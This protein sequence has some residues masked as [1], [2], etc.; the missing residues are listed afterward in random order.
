LGQRIDPENRLLWKRTIE[1]LDAEEIRD[2]MLAVSGELDPVI[3]GPSVPTSRPRRTVFTRV[4]RNVR[5]QFL[6]AFDA[7][8]GN[9]T[10]PRRNSTTAATQALLMING[11][12]TLARAKAVAA[13]L[14]PSSTD[15]SDRIV[16]AYRLALGRRPEPGEIADGLTFVKQQATRLT[17]SAQRS[18]LQASR[19]ALVDFCHVLLN[20]NEFLYVD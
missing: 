1:R 18:D 7:P 16:L 14:E 11:D 15:A 6:E 13:R 8:D 3:A 10:T 2:A 4:V 9:S 20:S 17:P 19:E 5:D 12:W